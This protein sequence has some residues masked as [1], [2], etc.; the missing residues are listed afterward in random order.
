MIASTY[1]DGGAL[2]IQ[3]YLWA[4]SFLEMQASPLSVADT[5]VGILVIYDMG[6]CSHVPADGIAGYTD[7]V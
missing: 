1:L 6:T 7:L 5:L 2:S 3:M 4:C